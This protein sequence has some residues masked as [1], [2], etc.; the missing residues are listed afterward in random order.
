MT[1]TVTMGLVLGANRVEGSTLQQVAVLPTSLCHTFEKR[2]KTRNSMQKWLICLMTCVSCQS[3]VQKG[4]L[5]I[6]QMDNEL[7]CNIISIHS[8]QLLEKLSPKSHFTNDE[9]PFS[10]HKLIEIQGHVCRAMRIS[11]VGEMGNL[12]NYFIYL[13][14]LIQML[15]QLTKWNFCNYYY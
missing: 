6:I 13:T 1:F 8:R 12:V 2:S 3:K 10:T 4:W 5:N 15:K 9:F 7:I 14:N 11:F